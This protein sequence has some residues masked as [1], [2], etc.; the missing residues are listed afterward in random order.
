MNRRFVVT[1]AVE[2]TSVGRLLEAVN[3]ERKRRGFEPFR[4]VMLGVEHRCI[5]EIMDSMIFG[6]EIG[7]LDGFMRVKHGIMEVD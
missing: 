7:A 4:G 3:A 6:G 5:G 1:I 2:V